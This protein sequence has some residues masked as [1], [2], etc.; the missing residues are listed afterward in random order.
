MHQFI[1]TRKNGSMIWNPANGTITWKGHLPYEGKHVELDSIYLLGTN[2]DLYGLQYI[3]DELGNLW[4]NNIRFESG[5]RFVRCYNES[6]DHI[7]I[8]TNDK[9]MVFI[10]ATEDSEPIKPSYEELTITI[11][12]Y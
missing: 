7:H 4:T 10:L 12:F 8:Y 2:A 11:N 3:T 1:L 5:L 9:P 6:K